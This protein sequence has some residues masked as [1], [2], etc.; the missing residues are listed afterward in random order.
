MKKRIG[1]VLVL[2][3]LICFVTSCTTLK[4]NVPFGYQPSLINVSKKINKKVGFEV[5]TDKRPVNEV[6]ATERPIQDITNKITYKLIEDFKSSGIFEEINFPAKDGDDLI[7][8]GEINKFIWR[9]DNNW[10]AVIFF[11]LVYF[12]L[13]VGDYVGETDITLKLID[14][15]TGQVLGT[16]HGTGEQRLTVTLYSMSVGEIGS[17]LAEAFRQCAKQLKEKIL[18]DI[19]FQ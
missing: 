2:F 6:K 18:T 3:V 13:P 11:P 1:T 12:G 7:I 9:E 17:E 15:K 4:G 10:F 19:S 8:K 14:K 5:L 16:V